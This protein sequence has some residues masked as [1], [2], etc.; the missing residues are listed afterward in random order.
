[1]D[2]G[3]QV[4]DV[5]DFRNSWIFRPRQNY[6]HDGR[7]LTLED[8]VEFFNLVLENQVD[9]TREA[10]LDCILARAIGQKFVAESGIEFFE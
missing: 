4:H 10:R 6:L 1:L 2:R 5:A 8:T 3:S 9:V 7:L